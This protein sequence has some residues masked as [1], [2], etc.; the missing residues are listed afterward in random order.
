MRHQLYQII[1]LTGVFMVFLSYGGLIVRSALGSDNRGLRRLGGMTSGIG[2]FL[3]LLGG[4]GL[5]ARLNYGWPLWVLVKVAIWVIL[6]GL[7][8][9]INRKPQFSQI[10]WWTT[11]LLGVVALLMVILKPTL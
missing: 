5:L 2:L 6:G 10:L 8:V 1:H 3:I 9:L 7:I 4:F 11:I